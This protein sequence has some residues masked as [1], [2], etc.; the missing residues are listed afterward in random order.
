[1]SEQTEQE[2]Y[3]H[4]HRAWNWQWPNER[5]CFNTGLPAPRRQHANAHKTLWSY[6]GPSKRIVAKRAARR[7]AKRSH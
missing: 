3:L 6:Q 7:A 5:N 4:K 1:M 2:R